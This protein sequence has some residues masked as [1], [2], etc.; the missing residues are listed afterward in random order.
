[1]RLNRF[2]LNLLVALHALLEEH[3][4]TRAA[5]RLNLTQSAMSAALR[6]LRESFN[7]EILIPHGKKMVPTSHAQGLAP[8]VAQTLI[9]MQSLLSSS[10]VFDPAT[11]QRTFRIAASDYITAVLVAPLLTELEAVTPGVRVEVMPP[12]SES[13]TLLE[14]G[15]LDFLLTPEQFLAVDHPKQLL[16]EERHVVVGWDQNPIFSKPL[17]EEAFYTAGHVAV[18]ISGR[19]TFAEEVLRERDDRR[20][21]EV[22]APSF[23]LVP[24]MLPG[25]HRIAVMHERLAKAMVDKFPLTIVPVPFAFPLMSEMIQYHRARSNDGGLNWLLGKLLA[26]AAARSIQA[27]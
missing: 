11:S 23:V 19:P 26:M 25:T 4:V 2:D 10:M 18:E 22:V 12:S 1:M 14:R 27:S 3:S 5:A 17:T 8:L 13:V 16:F 15:T 24:F 21:I 7:D 6:R 9:N 20:R